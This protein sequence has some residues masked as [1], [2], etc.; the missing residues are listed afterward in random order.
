M[1]KKTKKYDDVNELKRLLL[2]ERKLTKK[3][4]KENQDLNLVIDKLKK[5]NIKIKKQLENDTVNQLKEKIKLLENEII[6]KNKEIQNYI[7]QLNNTNEKNNEDDSAKQEE[8]NFSLIFNTQSNQDIINYGMPCKSTDLF[9]R[10]E[11]RLYNEFPKYKNYETFFIDK[12]RK[13]LRFKTLEENKINNNDIISLLYN[14]EKLI[15]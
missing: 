8:N 4:T 15:Q 3:L 10:L 14:E 9:V 12:N 7:S 13:I 5:E 11:E 6:K 2:D 1:N